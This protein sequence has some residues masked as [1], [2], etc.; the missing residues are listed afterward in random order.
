M[1]GPPVCT[2]QPKGKPRA[3]KKKARRARPSTDKNA[4][5][6][7]HSLIV[8]SVG[9]C[10]R[11]HRVTDTLQCAHIV[12]RRFS[13]TRCVRNNAW[14]LCAKCH[15]ALTEDPYAHV[16]FAHQTIGEEHYGWLRA[17]ALNGPRPDWSVVAAELRLEWDAI[18]SAV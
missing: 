8:R 12:S 17:L 4:A 11:C 13:A 15:L 7:L 9:Y 16:A 2:P 10:E 3:V 1:E 18:E 6:R 5:T 14:C